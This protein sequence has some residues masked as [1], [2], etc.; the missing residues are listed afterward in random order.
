[1]ATRYVEG[2]MDGLIVLARLMDRWN[3]GEQTTQ[4]AAEIR[5][6][7]MPYG[8]TPLDRNRLQWKIEPAAAK[9]AEPKPEPKRAAFDPRKVLEMKR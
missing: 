7:R 1:M 8:L 9:P 3:C 6:Q 5:L 4:L 2:D